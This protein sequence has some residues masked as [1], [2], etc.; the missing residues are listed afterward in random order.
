MDLL[1]TTQRRRS[2]QCFRAITVVVLL[3]S[4]GTL[5]GATAA[6]EP[7]RADLVKAA[8]LLKLSKY[9]SWPSEAMEGKEEFTVGII[10]SKD[11]AMAL[12]DA[13]K[14]KTMVDMPVT[15]IVVSE[16]DDLEG[17]DL[18]YFEEGHQKDEYLEALASRPV[19]VYGDGEK[20]AEKSGQIGLFER[21]NKIRFT[22]N[23][24]A[25]RDVGLT[26]SSKVLDLASQV[27]G[28][29]E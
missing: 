8:T 24:K 23:L 12:D 29:T 4:T 17:C 21:D 15:T 19:L 6:A 13:F 16:L 5:V 20:F 14:G 9:V 25:A 7:S 10:A 3:F 1:K 28:S 11:M 2:R 22:I 18:V 26:I 27:Y